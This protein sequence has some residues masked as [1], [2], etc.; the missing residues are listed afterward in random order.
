MSDLAR[1]LVAAD[2]WRWMP[3]MRAVW[4]SPSSLGSYRLSELF[5][6]LR[7]HNV[8]DWAGLVP[9]LSDPATIGCVLALVREKHHNPTIVAVPYWMGRELRWWTEIPD[10]GGVDGATEAEALVN[11]LCAK[12]SR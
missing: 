7:T 9:D 3:G 4:E 10:Q 1:K 11:A 5:D 2:G 8:V 12:E 6:G